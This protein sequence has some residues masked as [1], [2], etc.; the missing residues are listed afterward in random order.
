MQEHIKRSR[1]FNTDIRAGFSTFPPFSA[2]SAADEASA[3]WPTRRR[4]DVR[5]RRE[6]ASLDGRSVG[7]KTQVASSSSSSFLGAALFHVPPSLLALPKHFH[8]LAPPA[9]KREMGRE[10]ERADQTK[11]RR[12]PLSNSGRFMASPPLPPFASCL[13]RASSFSA[14]SVCVCVVG[15]QSGYCDVRCIA[16]RVCKGGLSLPAAANQPRSR[17]HGKHAR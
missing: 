17:S 2:A 8:R 10:G 11:R 7:R 4:C 1:G 16:C 13:D 3:F 15:P 9:G 6:P 5:A 14:W 12:R